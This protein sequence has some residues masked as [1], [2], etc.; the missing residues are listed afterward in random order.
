MQ[1]INWGGDNKLIYKYMENK[2]YALPELLYAHNSLEP[3]V[4]EEQL[5]IHHEKHHATYV[6]TANQILEKIA[7][8]R[9]DNTELDMRAELKA[10]SFNVGG[11]ILHSLFWESMTPSGQTNEEMKKRITEEFGSW[12]RFK[13][14]FSQTASSVEGSGWAA[15]ICAPETGQLLLMQIEKHNVSVI[16]QSDIILVLDVFEHAYYLD[17]KN[18]RAKFIEAFWSVIDWNKV[19]E[20]LKN[21]ESK[22]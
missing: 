13:S 18:D 11:H 17:Y 5:K 8:A 20:R 19:N 10:L 16:P 7:K 2:S 14:E 4:S 6:K 9:T 3:F 15:L 21:I 22:V 1:R 12:E